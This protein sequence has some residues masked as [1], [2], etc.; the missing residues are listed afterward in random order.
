MDIKL[1]EQLVKRGPLIVII[2]FTIF[3]SYLIWENIGVSILATIGVFFLYGSGEA[4][5]YLMWWN[6]PTLITSDGK[7]RSF[8]TVDKYPIISP[9]K[10]DYDYVLYVTGGSDWSWFPMRGGH[11]MYPIVFGPKEY[12]ESFVGGGGDHFPG[13]IHQIPDDSIPEIARQI[14]EGHPYAKIGKNPFLR[15]DVTFKNLN[16]TDENVNIAKQR[17]QYIADSKAK[18]DH[19]KKLQEQLRGQLSLER[20]IDEKSKIFSIFFY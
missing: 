20:A 5:P 9:Y 14:I 7:K 18:D 12:V 3:L 1:Y 19:I 6:T 10:N 4:I 13:N 2:I 16:Y 11:L 17:D 15:I 8:R